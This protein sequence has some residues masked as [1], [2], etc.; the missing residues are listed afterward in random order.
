MEKLPPL[1]PL[2]GMLFQTYSTRGKS[3]NTQANPKNG[4]GIGLYD[5]EQHRNQK[6][7][8]LHELE[9]DGTPVFLTISTPDLYHNGPEFF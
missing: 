2:F 4:E 6:G 3:K 1:P 8:E 5:Q 9:A 7:T